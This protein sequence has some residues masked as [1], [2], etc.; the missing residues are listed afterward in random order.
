[1]G[2]MVPSRHQLAQRVHYLPELPI[3][4]R[5]HSHYFILQRWS[6]L[7]PA[8]SA[9]LC[10][11]VGPQPKTFATPLRPLARW[12]SIFDSPVPFLY[13]C[14]SQ[15]QASPVNELA[16]CDC[17][18][19]CPLC[20]LLC[21]CEMSINTATVLIWQHPAPTLCRCKWL[22][23]T[24]G[25]EKLGPEFIGAHAPLHSVLLRGTKET[26]RNR[27]APQIGTGGVALWQAPLNDW[28]FFI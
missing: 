19:L 14:S 6:P 9:G 22:L 13:P 10:R 12:N 17:P 15:S 28:G 1:M 4:Q 11:G 5:E 2:F 25:N 27:H 3:G 26:R 23:R 7:L 20:S 8:A 16:V 18:L 24:R 21:L